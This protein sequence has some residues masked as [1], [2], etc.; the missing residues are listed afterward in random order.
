MVVRDNLSNVRSGERDHTALI[1]QISNVPPRT[2]P[3]N[4]SKRNVSD[5][6]LLRQTSDKRAPTGST[7]ANDRGRYTLSNGVRN[8][9]A[10]NALAGENTVVANFIG[11]IG[12]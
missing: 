4:Q 6:A 10:P 1:P 9:I 2:T 7:I 3:G 5:P 11:T 12:T 8:A